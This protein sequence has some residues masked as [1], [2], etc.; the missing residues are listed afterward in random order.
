MKPRADV[1]ALL[2]AGATYRQIHAALGVGQAT[3]AATRKAYNIPLPP[4]RSG[5]SRRGTQAAQIEARIAQMLR[6]G[7][8]YAAI[9]T[10]LHVSALR[11]STIRRKHQI[12][13]PPGR[14]PGLTSA[15]TPEQTL[16]HYSQPTTDG[17]T[18]WTGPADASGKPIIWTRH[19]ALNGRRIA[20][21]LHHRRE[22]E[23]RVTVACQDPHCITGAHLTDRRIRQANH[24]AD[25]AY[26][27][28]FGTAP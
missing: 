3:I 6:D 25:Q 21:H 16:A 1:A 15:R 18:H 19:K 11:I 28:L 14:H 20:F 4:G 27:R 23:G 22:P 8:T 10:E 26:E 5:N 7:A 24:R 13:L 2:R 12:P 17:H 9:R